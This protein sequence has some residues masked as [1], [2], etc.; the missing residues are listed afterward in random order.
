[1]STN[2]T[3]AEALDLE[4]IA[5]GVETPQQLST[6]QGLD[7]RRARGFYVSRPLTA[8]ALSRLIV[9]RVGRHAI[10]V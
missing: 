10:R 1:M 7:C 8:D 3:M 9:A 6:L 5:E 4:V 2:S